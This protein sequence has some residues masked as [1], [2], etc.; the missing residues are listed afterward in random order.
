MLEI[1]RGT[2]TKNYENTFFR[3]FAENLEKLF[4]KYSVDGLLIANSECEAEK[5]LQID[6]LLVT[7]NVVCIIDF[8]NFGGKIKLPK[9]GKG[10][11]EFGRWTNDSGEIVKGG[12]SVN[13][14][15]QLKNQKERFI[16]VCKK[17]IIPN[18]NNSDKLNAYHTVR[19]VCFQKSIEL[20]G[21]IPSREEL[22]FFIIDQD[23]YLE[24]IKDI[25]DITS[26]DVKLSKN[27]F[28][29]FKEVFRADKF[30]IKETYSENIT[31]DATSTVLDYDNL[32]TDQK[33]A[34]QEITEFIK[35][36]TEKVFIIQGTSLSGK[37]HLIPFIEEIA[38]NN[39][40]AQ[41]ELFASSSRVATNLLSEHN[42]KFNSLYSYIYGGGLQ[43]TQS[44]DKE[45]ETKETEDNTEKIKL[46]IVPLKKSDNENKAIFIVDEA[47]LISDNYHQSIDLRFGSGKLLEDFIKFS[48]L[49]NSNRKIIFIGDSFQLSIG[50]KEENTLNPEYIKEKY[51]FKTKAFQLIDKE[52][53]SEIIKQAL[54]SV[55]S[56]R[57]K[58]FNQLIFKPTDKINLLNTDNK[59][60]LQNTIKSKIEN[61]IDFH[62]LSY[63]NFDAQKVNNW[64]KKTIIKNGENIAKKDLIIFNNNFKVEDANDP[65]SKPKRVFNGQFGTV[66]NVSDD[67][68][69]ETITPKGK[70]PITLKYREIS[71]LLKDTGHNATVLSLE[72]YRLSDKGELSEDEIIALKIILN[73][74]IKI[75]ISKYPFD[76]S[77]LFSQ[78]KNSKEYKELENDISSLKVKL[79]NGEKVKTKLEETERKLR[80]IINSAKGKHRK[81]FEKNLNKDSSSK[82]YKY[83]NSAQ[84]RF[85][86]TLTVHKSMSYKW[87]EIIFN[88]DQGENR[89]K[90]NENYFKW[91]YTGLTRAKNKVS[92]INYKPISPLLKCEFRDGNTG[93]S[94]DKKIYFIANIEAKLSNLDTALVQKFNFSE[95]NSFLLQVHQLINSKLECHNI[96]I[97]SINHPN[98][99]EH[100][101]LKGSNGEFATIS[102]YYNKKGQIKTPSLMNS[103]PSEF[104]DEVIKILTTNNEIKDFSFIKDKWRENIYIE[105]NKQLVKTNCYFDYII[106]VPYKDTV[107]INNYNSEF[108]VDMY[109]DGDGFFS[110]ISTSYYSEIEIWEKFKTI[111]NNLKE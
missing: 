84:I 1:R 22:N 7:E 32:Y 107:R 16:N 10:E 96:S 34:L 36:D 43:E 109:Y 9:N 63:S 59:T 71:I 108:I 73:R 87:D 6:A 42:L 24:K 5:R 4:D 69:V 8:K 11:F 62:I 88:I 103:T 17:H 80:K 94:N 61:N 86:W 45:S 89:G 25:I 53:N 20:D 47:Q 35:S 67:L 64:I 82:Y 101:E 18:L 21:S 54:Q 85:G 95:E 100:Y 15:I 92:L 49:K 72:N 14:F 60:D 33:T 13:P 111:L 77:E 102:F 56:I 37:T 76:N 74:E 110:S 52:D 99:Q 70:L 30:N 58:T 48:D 83:K 66:A 23:N 93:V 57:N 40:I 106:Q 3:K 31:F 98:Y 90:S 39:E 55:Q 12:N 50:K 44:E 75:A 81:T 65:F 68:I 19:M 97:H 105:I 104:G 51:E 79:S 78:L 26:K 91:I 28:D 27:S 41:V 2:A 29:L 46:E 38:Y